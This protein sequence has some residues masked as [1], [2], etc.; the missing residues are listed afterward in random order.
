MCRYH[1][2]VCGNH[3]LRKSGYTSENRVFRV[4]ITP[5]R[6]VMTVVHAKITLMRVETTMRVE[7]T[8]VHWT[9]LVEKLKRVN[10][11]IQIQNTHSYM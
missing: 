10:K 1:T 2:R 9:L 8:L 11:L 3:T 4:K 5:V 7:I 6:E